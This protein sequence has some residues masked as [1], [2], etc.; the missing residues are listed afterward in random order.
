MRV[1]VAAGALLLLAAAGGR[2]ARALD[3]TA[4]KGAWERAQVHVKAERWVK[5]V[6]AL[7]QMLEHHP[8][9]P[10]LL[11]KLESVETDLRRCMFRAQAKHPDA[12]VLFG[13]AALGFIVKERRLTLEYPQGP[14]G[15]DW[16]GTSYEFLHRVP[17]DDDLALEFTART[18]HAK[19]RTI[20][21]IHLVG[22][23]PRNPG[24]QTGRYE[25]VPG[26]F[27]VDGN[28]EYVARG[29]IVRVDAAETGPNGARRSL[30][31]KPAPGTVAIDQIQNYRVVRRDGGINV[32]VDGKPFLLC[33]DSKHPI[34]VVRFGGRDVGRT[35]VRG[36]VEK[37][38]YLD[39]LEKH[40][41]AEQAVWEKTG[42]D[43]GKVLP[44]WIL[45]MEA[46]MR[47]P[48]PEGE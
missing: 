40:Y 20:V 33:Q 7:R 45:D 26:V 12:K 9:S 1:P 3:E 35:V 4:V 25:I 10:W 23:D 22:V 21:C 19:S 31:D 15:D 14:S 48:R 44:G 18:V 36:V 24:V 37:T 2:P 41:A 43:R 6:D 39:L 29:S 28:Y 42:Y 16:T 17:F 32:S 38:Y 47:E 11:K 27:S 13:G 34:N 46:K 5:A 30:V 8:G